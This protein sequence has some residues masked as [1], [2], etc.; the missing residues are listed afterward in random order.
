M[1][2]GSVFTL[3]TYSIVHG[4]WWHLGAN[5]L[6]LWTFADNVEDALGHWRFLL[7]YVLGGAIAALAQGLFG[8]Q[9]LAPYVGASGAVAACVGGYVLLYPRARIWIL[10]LMRIPL[11]VPAWLAG[12]MFLVTQLLFLAFGAEPSV[13]W[14]G[15]LAGFAGGMLMVVFLRQRGVQLWAPPEPKTPA[16]PAALV[17]TP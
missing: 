5:M 12:I 1:A 11:P 4:S 15:H 6:F 16:K 10:F 13:G 2:R 3:L 8:G 9:P 14:T 17:D 7:F